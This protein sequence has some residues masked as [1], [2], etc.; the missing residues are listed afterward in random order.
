MTVSIWESLEIIHSKVRFFE[1]RDVKHLTWRFLR[2][3]A[4]FRLRINRTLSEVC[5]CDILARFVPITIQNQCVSDYDQ[6]VVSNVQFGS[7]KDADTYCENK[8]L[9]LLRLAYDEDNYR[10][11][12]LACSLS[13]HSVD[14]GN[15]AFFSGFF[16]TSLVNMKISF[17]AK[18]IMIV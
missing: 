5:L 11:T 7:W 1:W 9:Q 17:C 10:F 4:G 18:H 14:P 6:F 15:S 2:T 3:E 12:S 13:R 16:K 8:G